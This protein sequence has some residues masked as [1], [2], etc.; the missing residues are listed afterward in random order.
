MCQSNTIKPEQVIG[1]PGKEPEIDQRT[2]HSRICVCAG[3]TSAR[4]AWEMP[5][6]PR[7]SL[8]GPCHGKC[9]MPRPLARLH[10]SGARRAQCL[11]SGVQVKI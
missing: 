11:V 2:R 8:G 5:D 1:V 6:L 10:R 4:G 3:A 9:Q 7:E